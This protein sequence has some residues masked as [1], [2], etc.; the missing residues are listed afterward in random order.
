MAAIIANTDPISN[1]RTEETV[2]NTDAVR[3][4]ASISLNSARTLTSLVE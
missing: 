2:K 3:I 4:E 1:Q